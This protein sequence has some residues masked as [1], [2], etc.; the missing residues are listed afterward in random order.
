MK[1]HATKSSRL[2]S[3]EKDLAYIIDGISN[4]GSDK[5]IH[6]SRNADK[7]LIKNFQLALGDGN[8]MIDPDRS[9]RIIVKASILGDLQKADEVELD[10]FYQKFLKLQKTSTLETVKSDPNLNR[11]LIDSSN[12]G[13]IILAKSTKMSSTADFNNTNALTK[14]R[15]RILCSS[16]RE[17][18]RISSGGYFGP[19]KCFA[20]L[21]KNLAFAMQS[22]RGV[23][24]YMFDR[25]I[26]AIEPVD[27]MFF[28]KAKFKQHF[29]SI[30]MEEQKKTPDQLID[31]NFLRPR[32]PLMMPNPPAIPI[33][34][35]VFI[36]QAAMYIATWPIA[37][38]ANTLSRK[39]KLESSSYL[40]EPAYKKQDS[41]RSVKDLS[42]H[43]ILA[44]VSQALE[45]DIAPLQTSP[46][47]GGLAIL[48]ART[49]EQFMYNT[50]YQKHHN[51]YKLPNKHMKTSFD[52]KNT[53][54]HT[55]GLTVRGDVV[56]FYGQ[57]EHEA[58]EVILHELMHVISHKIEHLGKD[59][60]KADYR[61]LLDQSGSWLKQF[62]LDHEINFETFNNIHIRRSI[63]QGLDY[64]SDDGIG[65]VANLVP[66]ILQARAIDPDIFDTEIKRPGNPVTKLFDQLNRDSKAILAKNIEAIAAR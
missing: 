46:L 35:T 29:P 26:I 63:S 33:V 48:I 21:Y 11:Y 51:C 5:A 15:D 38:M 53:P 13:A 65:Y 27:I 24:Q 30:M 49:H 42:K 56:E 64:H 3:F 8:A 52:N 9:D 25:G 1:A 17:R 32:R 19:T 45:R 2:S 12:D 54:L 61:G 20:K 23:S 39:R 55:K 62:C 4:D 44:K 14:Y 47:N 50:L 18:A 6:F 37:K 60:Y 43:E 57:T 10:K 59:K 66:K 16:D 22:K 34:L 40:D 36:I 41:K 31:P 28:N 7:N 58:R